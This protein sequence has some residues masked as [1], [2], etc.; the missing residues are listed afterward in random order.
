MNSNDTPRGFKSKTII[1][2]IREKLESWIKTIENESLQDIIRQDAIVTGGAITS[3]LQGRLPN[4]YDVYFCNTET[5]LKVAQYYLTRLPESQNEKVPLVKAEIDGT[6]VKIMIKS[7]GMASEGN[8]QGEYEY[9]EFMPDG[10]SDAYLEKAMNSDSGKFSV[11]CMT[12]NAITLSDKIQIILRFT[13]DVNEIHK[14]YDFV[15]CTNCYRDGKLTIRQDALLSII[16]KELRYIGSL[17]PVC[18]MF[19]L[20]K[21]IKRGWTITA[22]EMFKIAYDISKLNLDDANIL[23][24][25]LTGVDAAYFNEVIN[26]LRKESNRDINRTYL[27][28]LISRVFDEID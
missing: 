15:H 24:D 14:N 23:E 28:E 17:Y 2:N 12:T 5:A 26:I 9:F 25:Q 19:R 16:T 1:K 20:K 10:A 18:S 22:G 13:G 21:F 3:M 27:F 6:R 7:S 11:V 8:D 4:D